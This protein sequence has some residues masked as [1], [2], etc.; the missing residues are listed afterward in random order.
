MAYNVVLGQLPSLRSSTGESL[1][2][3]QQ[4]PGI[5]TLTCKAMNFGTSGLIGWYAGDQRLARFDITL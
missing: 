1:L 4:S 2:S 3:G 5:L